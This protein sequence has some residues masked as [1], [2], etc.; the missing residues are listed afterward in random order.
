MKQTAIVFA[1]QGA[2]AVGMG[3]DLADALP[4]CRELFEKADAAVG[5]PLSK[6]CFEGPAEEL[7]KTSHCQP[8]IFVVSMACYAALRREAPALQ[9]AAM[10]GL[11]LGEWTALHAAGVLGFEDTVRVLAAR[12][13]FMQEACDREAGGML[14]VIGLTAEQLKPVCAESGAELANL[15]SAQQTVLS[16]SAAAVA[17]AEALA[18]QAGAKMVVALKVAGAYH[19]ALMRP[20]AEKLRAVLAQVALRAPRVPVIANVTGR[21]HGEPDSIRE[22]MLRQVT[23]PVLW[24]AGVEWLLSQGCRSFVECGPGKVLAGL[25]KRID[26]DTQAVSAP[27]LESVRVAAAALG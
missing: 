26:K 27:D 14:S 12:G 18:K 3:K 16:G 24:Q 7:T 21:P 8:A 11:S 17:R 23:S 22:T 6:L 19:S 10:A 15:N 13:R 1:G 9:P 25:I 2:Q 5:Y 20:A 4:E